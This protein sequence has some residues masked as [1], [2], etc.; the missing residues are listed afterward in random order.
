LILILA[1]LFQGNF[2]QIVPVLFA[3]VSVCLKIKLSGHVQT[4]H[5]NPVPDMTRD[6]GEQYN[7]ID[8][9]P[10][11]VEDLMKVAEA[12]RAE[13]GDLNIGLAKGS[14]SREIGRD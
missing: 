11:I 12:E 3:Q 10:E 13:P 1:Q 14:G 9:N 4:N 8:S 6:P 2:N 7:V 5:R